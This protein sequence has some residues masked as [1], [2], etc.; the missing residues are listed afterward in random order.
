MKLKQIQIKNVKSFREEV[1]FIPHEQFNV[2]IGSNGGGKSNL[3][4]I[5]HVSLRHFL[6]WAY[7]LQSEQ[8]DEG[9]R[10]ILA[11]NH[12]PFGAIGQLLAKYTGDSSESVILLQ[13]EVTESDVNNISRISSQII[14]IKQLLSGYYFVENDVRSFLESS[15]EQL[16]QLNVGDVYDFKI[17]NNQ[18]QEPKEEKACLYKKYLNTIEAFGLLSQYL[19]VEF[20]PIILYISPFR[21][22]SRENLEKSLADSTS[23]GER[24]ELMKSTSRSSSSLLS[25]ATLFFAEKHRNYEVEPCGWKT[26]W[27]SDDHVQFVTNTLAKIGYSWDLYL[28]N[29]NRNIYSIKLSKDGREYLLNQA[30]SGEVELIN[31]IFGLVASG[32]KDSIIIVDEPELHLHPKWIAFLREILRDYAFNENNQLM[33]ITHSASFINTSTYPYITRV[34]KTSKGNSQL[35]KVFCDNMGE[36]KEKLHFINATNNEKVFF[37]DF[38]VMV[39]GDTDEIVYKQI[40]EQIKEELKINKIVEVVQIKGKN[41]YGSFSDFLKTLQIDSCYIG[42]LDNIS[43]FSDGNEQINAMLVTNYRNVDRMVIKNPGS[44]DYDSLIEKLTEACNTR[45]IQA[46]SSFLDY[47]SSFRRKIKP[48]ITSEEKEALLSFIESL[49]S[50]GIFLLTEG[51]IED[52]FPKELKLKNL[53]NALQ[54]TEE[55]AFAKWKKESGY[56]KLHDLLTE[57][58]RRYRLIN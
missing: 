16:E 35:F 26:K 27:E 52:Y 58:L 53:D 45:D 5:L 48:D 25:L 57:I 55:E 29:T 15:Q 54:L 50:K 34:Y 28:T 51:E 21:S 31:F 9:V 3:M 4:E 19:N 24:T 30:S 6:V 46:L 12:D 40:L 49:K 7:R 23:C 38:V 1:S 39:E 44:K 14:Q 2:L 17:V 41:N 37:S 32:H 47:I 43:Q 42:D 20:Y 10:W 22:V 18:L 33:V 56:K 8:A 11:R 36:T 13:L